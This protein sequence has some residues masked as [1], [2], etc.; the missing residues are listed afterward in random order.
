VVTGNNF[1]HLVLGR[2]LS[3]YL[4]IYGF[5]GFVFPLMQWLVLVIGF[6]L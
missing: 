4:F 2:I 1:I 5:T 3:L 6:E